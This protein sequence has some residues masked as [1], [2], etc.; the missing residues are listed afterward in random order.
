M[1]DQ[2]ASVFVASLVGLLAAAFWQRM[3][4]LRALANALDHIRASFYMMRAMAEICWD[5]RDRWRECLDRA[6]R[7]R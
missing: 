7:E 1:N 2:T 5:H 3:G 4:P 6:R